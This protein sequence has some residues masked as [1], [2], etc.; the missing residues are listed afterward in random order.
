PGAALAQR[1]ARLDTGRNLEVDPRSVNSGKGHRAPKRGGSEADRAIGNQIARVALEN[2]MALH[3]DE[4]VEIAAR[5]PANSGLAFAGNANPGAFVD[6]GGNIDVD[7]AALE[8]TAIAL[9]GPAWISDHFAR[10]GALRAHSLD[11]EEALV[12]ADL[13]SAAAAGAARRARLAPRS[14]PRTAI[15]FSQCLDLDILGG[16]R[17]RFLQRQVEVVAQVGT[18]RCILPGTARIH[19]LAENRRENI[20]KAFEPLTTAERIAAGAAAAILESG[21][22]EAIVSGAL[23]RVFQDVIGLADC[24]EMRF[25][26]SAAA[27]PIGVAVHGL[28]AIS[29]LDRRV[30]RAALHAEQF[31]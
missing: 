17:K 26:V 24:L 5:R 15:A 30:I 2:R 1:F 18:P 8:R 20:G 28:L 29:G 12:G 3:V 11:H 16:A 23:L 6:P 9:A 10:P 4:Q 31:I 21:M 13:T 27:V 22:A 19:K 14:L 25:L 7:F